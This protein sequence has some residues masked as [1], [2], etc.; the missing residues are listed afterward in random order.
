M[1]E[2]IC[3]AKRCTEPAIWALNWRNPRIHD[4]A[5]VKTW[6]ACEGHREHLRD[7]LAAR[8]FPLTVVPLSEMRGEGRVGD[9]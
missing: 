2:V 6:V 5:R 3:S 9:D 1:T 8:D 7:F 4:A